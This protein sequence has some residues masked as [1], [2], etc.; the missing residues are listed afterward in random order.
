M[1]PPTLKTDKLQ[2]CDILFLGLE[3]HFNFTVNLSAW[4][5]KAAAQ[6]SRR[7]CHL[8]ARWWHGTSTGMPGM[9]PFRSHRLVYWILSLIS[10]SDWSLS[11]PHTRWYN[12]SA[13][14]PVWV[15]FT[16]RGYFLQSGTQAPSYPRPRLHV[17][18]CIWTIWAWLHVHSTVMWRGEARE[19]WVTCPPPGVCPSV[20][21]LG[22][23]CVR[24]DMRRMTHGY[25]YYFSISLPTTH[26]H[27]VWSLTSCWRSILLTNEM[28]L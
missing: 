17:L 12:V 6:N 2:V 7:A 1:Y 22:L 23:G 27:S 5:V 24:P 16:S 10:A 19:R 3:I 15:P 4:Q 28:Q 11:I 13:H 14:P 26:W 21:P 20:R 18:I 9:S 8:V 25:F